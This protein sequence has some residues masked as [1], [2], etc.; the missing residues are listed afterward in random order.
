MPEIPQSK[1][2]AADTVSRPGSRVIGGND[3]DDIEFSEI[4]VELIDED[5][6]VVGVETVVEVRVV[7]FVVDVDGTRCWV[8]A[9]VCCKRVVETGFTGF[10]F[11]I[12]VK[13]NFKCD[14]NVLINFLKS[15]NNFSS[16]RW[17][18]FKR[19]WFSRLE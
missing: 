10:A 16:Y 2:R 14:E 18:R 6:L 11:F 15:L 7:N 3:S 19:C 17:F 8:Y 9:V 13:E 5:G 4:S 1:L 12:F